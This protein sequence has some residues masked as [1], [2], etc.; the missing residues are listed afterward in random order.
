MAKNNNNTKKITAQKVAAS[1]T[2]TAAK[3]T[4]NR[5]RTRRTRAGRSSGGLLILVVVLIVALVG[6]LAHYEFDLL[7]LRDSGCDCIP[8][9]PYC[10]C[11]AK[12][13]V[14]SPN[15]AGLARVYFMD[16]GQ[17][18]YII[19]SMPDGFNMIVDGGSSTAFAAATGRGYAAN[20][21]NNL[22]ISS[23]DFMVATHS[24]ADHINL[25][26]YILEE[27]SGISVGTVVYND[28]DTGT[29][30][31]TTFIQHVET[32]ADGTIVVGA[33]A[34]VGRKLADEDSYTITMYA[35]GNTRSTNEMSIIILIE[36]MGVNVLLMGDAETPTENWFMSVYSDDLT[37]DVLKTG[38]HGATASTSQAFID[39]FKPTFAIV[40]VGESNTHNHPT[41]FFMNRLF[42][43]GIMT[44]RTNRHGNIMLYIDSDGEFGFKVDNEVPVENNLHGRFDRMYRRAA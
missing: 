29:A 17:G 7:G 42:N 36:Y 28:H 8:K 30:T 14:P 33:T 32:Y 6:M 35:W 22:G 39:R 10:E 3:T 44:Y 24:D 26:R 25:L 13:T 9:P 21:R 41:P 11:E 4:Q 34:V 27:Q 19:V 16:V 23:F 1:I 5:T 43:N 37:I 40:S 31:Y 20:I 18:D 12:G 15:G 2:Q 38:H